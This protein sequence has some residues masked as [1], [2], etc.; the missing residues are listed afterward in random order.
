MFFH[1]NVKLLRNRR[2][3]TQDDVAFALG[4][5]RSTL[6]GYENQISEPGIDQLLAFSKYFGISIDTI[7]KVDLS[8]ISESQLSQIEKGYDIFISG[9]KLRVLATTVDSNNRDNVELITEKAKAGYKNGFAD[10]EFI[11]ALPVFQF[12]FLSK[13]RKYRTF[14][15]SG[16]SMLPIPDKSWVTGE[17]VQDWQMIRDRY[18]YII[19][20]KEDGI[21]FKIAENRLKE[22]KSLMLHSLNPLYEEYLL[23]VS[24]VRE[25]WKFVHYIS[26]ELPEANVPRET[27]LAETVTK[28]TKEIRE[29]KQYI[30]GKLF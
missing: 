11:K 13:E 1:T 6:S 21:V 9:G 27:E 18:P 16:D 22:E 10:P 2:G 8:K 15:I 23:P 30:Q 12:P 14:Q 24:E 29:M 5:K 3:R 17:Y 26:A 25:V 19:L 7:L 4:M 20:T 28:L